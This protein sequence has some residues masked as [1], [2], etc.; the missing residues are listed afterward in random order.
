MADIEHSAITDPEIHEPRGISAALTGTAYLANGL[1]S[2]AWTVVPSE[3][4]NAHTMVVIGG[5][6]TSDQGPSVTDT[7]HQVLFG[8]GGTVTGDI[9]INANGSMTVTTAG[10]Y[11][12][13]MNLNY[14]RTTSSGTAELNVRVLING[15]QLGGSGNTWLANSDSRITKTSTFTLTLAALDVLTVEIIRDSSGT[16]DG[17]LFIDALTPVDWNDVPSANIAA[18]KITL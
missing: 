7:P 11:L 18:Y 1:G 6:H 9:T 15:T 5:N 13:L 8:P 3:G 4:H 17:G 14:G 16:N 12:F 10:S 2:G